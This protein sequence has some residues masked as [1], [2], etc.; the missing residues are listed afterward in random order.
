MTEP[1]RSPQHDEI[2]EDTTDPL[3]AGVYADIRRASGLPGIN[4]FYRRLAY[5]GPQVLDAFWQQVKPLYVSGAL[6]RAGA[7]LQQHVPDS[8]R[9]ALDDSLLK[10]AGIASDDR[11]SVRATLKY[12]NQA[13]AM[14]LVLFSVI[15]RAL[16]SIGHGETPVPLAAVST[17]RNG[18]AELLPLPAWDDSPAASRVLIGAIRDR[19]AGGLDD[20]IRPTLLRHFAPYPVL[21]GSLHGY[22]ASREPELVAAIEAM[23]QVASGL[24]GT[25]SGDVAVTF[26]D[27]VRQVVA[28]TAGEFRQIIPVML[29]LGTAMVR[30]L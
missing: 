16:G 22:V 11:A 12:F 7:T 19:L 17:D 4:L 21:L 20:T 15:A 8:V 25:I 28:V 9:C 26:D 5:A 1:A 29:V 6:T 27:Q 2:P 18:D 10:A 24:A 3:I 14:H 23:R 13:N 30:G